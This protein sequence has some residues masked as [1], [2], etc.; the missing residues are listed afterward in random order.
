VEEAWSARQVCERAYAL[1][2]SASSQHFRACIRWGL[3]RPLE[4]GGWAPDTVR[5]LV[6][7]SRAASQARPLHRRVLVLRADYVNFPVAD[8]M[9]REAMIAMASASIEH[10]RR[11]LRAIVRLWNEWAEL[12]GEPLRW[13]GGNPWRGRA[14]VPEM[15]MPERWVGILQDPGLTD[16]IFGAQLRFAYQ[17]DREIAAGLSEWSEA[18]PLEERILLIVILNLAWRPAPAPQD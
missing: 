9:V 17:F 13:P 5:L 16:Q 14:P 4:G 8:D 10:S 18:M 3:V 1:G 11:K 2:A 15:P 6:S 12:Q 7:I